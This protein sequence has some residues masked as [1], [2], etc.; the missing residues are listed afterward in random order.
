M[1]LI[2]SLGPKATSPPANT[3]AAV[4]ASVS[5]STTIV[6]LGVISIPSFGFIHESSDAWPIA[7]TIVSASITDSE[8]S[9]NVGLNLPLSSNTDF[10]FTTSSPAAA[11]FLPI[12]L[13]GPR[14]LC[15]IIPSFAASLTSSSC[16]GISSR[17]SRQTM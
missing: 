15:I 9:I 17:D 4:V 13:F 5:G 1:A 7:I 11:P 16:A 8:P 3:A 2:S 6:R 12:I 14:E 10:T